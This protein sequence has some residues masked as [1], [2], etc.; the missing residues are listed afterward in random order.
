MLFLDVEI[1]R[2]ADSFRTCVQQK[3]GGALWI[4]VANRL[5]CMDSQEFGEEHCI[6]FAGP[7][8]ASGYI[9]YG[10]ELEVEEEF[11]EIY[12]DRYG[13]ENTDGVLRD[14]MEVI[15]EVNRERCTV[16][17]TIHERFSRWNHYQGEHELHTRV[18]TVSSPTDC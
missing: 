10:T 15:V 17:F 11:K 16:T 3:K 4:G 5:T 7:A 18:Y 6:M 12:E 9:H 2:E 13:S 8:F 1:G 14:G